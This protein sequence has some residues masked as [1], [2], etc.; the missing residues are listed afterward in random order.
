[1]I[2]ELTRING[3]SGDEDRVREFIIEKVKKYV[4]DLKVDSM[5]NLIVYKKGN[6]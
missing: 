5:G 2:K 6:K 1:V 3:V 4:D